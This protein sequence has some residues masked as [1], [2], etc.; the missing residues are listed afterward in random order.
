MAQSALT[1]IAKLMVVV[2][3]GLTLAGVIVY[4]LGRWG[5]PWQGLPGDMSFRRGGTSVHLPLA[6]SIVASAILSALLT[7]G[8]Y[9]AGRFRH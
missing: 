7:L 8:V 1:G 2:G 9:V 4:A 3:V 6:T 5:S